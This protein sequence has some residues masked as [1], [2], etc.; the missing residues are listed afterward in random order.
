MKSCNHVNGTWCL[1]FSINCYWL[2]PTYQ[3]IWLRRKAN[4]TAI[5]NR[6]QR[7]RRITW[8]LMFIRLSNSSGTVFSGGSSLSTAA[9]PEPGTAVF[10]TTGQTV[11]QSQR[12][13]FIGTPRYHRNVAV[14][15]FICFTNC[16]IA[17]VLPEHHSMWPVSK[18]IS[19]NL[20]IHGNTPIC[21]KIRIIRLNQQDTATNHRLNR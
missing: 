1:P 2:A 11:L 6:D 21:V 12:L 10:P 15:F 5:T 20:I 17:S 16:E 18:A 14:A 3:L 13:R 19:A 7:L 9:L 8:F 4:V